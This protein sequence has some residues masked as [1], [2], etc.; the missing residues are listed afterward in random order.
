MNTN[1]FLLAIVQIGSS[2][3]LGMSVMLF[4]FTIINRYAKWKYSIEQYNLS[5]AIIKAGILFS[6]GFL[7]QA[8]IQP[9][10]QT[11]RVYL[12]EE[13]QNF[14]D[15]L[16]YG[17]GHFALFFLI[18]AI[19]SILIVVI[20]LWLFTLLTSVINKVEEAEEIKNN[21]LSVGIVTSVVLVVMSI[22]LKDGLALLLES[23]IPYNF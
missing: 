13:N 11:V 15:I 20:S 8:V 21:N 3:V 10:M 18:A 22:L 14:W 23:I 2:L 7:M 4:S 19:Y 17:A 12:G 6:V 16:L 5:F 9:V 1:L